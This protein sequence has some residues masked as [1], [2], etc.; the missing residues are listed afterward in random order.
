MRFKI[1]NQISF[2][3]YTFSKKCSCM[4]KADLKTEMS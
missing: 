4:N 1:R 3:Q 2:D